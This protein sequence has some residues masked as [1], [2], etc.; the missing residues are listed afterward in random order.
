MILS[1]LLCDILVQSLSNCKRYIHYRFIYRECW[2]VSI[3]Y[4]GLIQLS[5]INI[6]MAD[7]YHLNFID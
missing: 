1:I 5:N 2:N 3:S 6:L 7:S 4:W